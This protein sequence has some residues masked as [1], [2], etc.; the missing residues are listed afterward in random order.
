MSNIEMEKTPDGM[1]VAHDIT[2]PPAKIVGR[3]TTE[4]IK[5]EDGSVTVASVAEPEPGEIPAARVKVLADGETGAVMTN[6]SD[7]DGE[8]EEVS[9]E[10]VKGVSLK[11]IATD[12]VEG[13]KEY[14]G[15]A[16]EVTAASLTKMVESGQIGG[17]RFI[18]PNQGYSQEYNP[19]RVQVFLD[20]EETVRNVIVG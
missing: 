18:P 3:S 2:E 8:S 10:K 20:A 14:V 19:S 6:V 7:P 16:K 9:W 12:V 11:A 5:G 13:L 4:F 1:V 17:F 15:Q